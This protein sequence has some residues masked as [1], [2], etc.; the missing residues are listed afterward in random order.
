[1]FMK[2]DARMFWADRKALL[3]KKQNKNKCTEQQKHLQTQAH[4]TSRQT[5]G[6][7]GF[8][9]YQTWTAI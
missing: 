9:L 4:Q 2:N 8:Y 7:T 1:M 3:T 6:H 5:K